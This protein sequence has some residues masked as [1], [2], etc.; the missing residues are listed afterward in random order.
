MQI[1]VT[2]QKDKYCLLYKARWKQY[3][4]KYNLLHYVTTFTITLRHQTKQAPR[5]DSRHNI[6]NNIF[7][8]ILPNLNQHH[9]YVTLRSVRRY[10]K[11]LRHSKDR[12][13][14]SLSFTPTLTIQ[15]LRKEYNKLQLGIAVVLQTDSL[16]HQSSFFSVS[17]FGASSVSF[18]SSL[19]VLDD[20]ASECFSASLPLLEML[21]RRMLSASVGVSVIARVRGG[22]VP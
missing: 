5:D 20:S 18:N 7:S 4:S 21:V 22:V 10:V 17:D 1:K 15:E 11:L 6:P 3:I 19:S 16:Y 8:I 14:S 13:I 2:Y 9:N 12:H